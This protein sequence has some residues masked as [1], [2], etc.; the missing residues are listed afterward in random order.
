MAI[1]PK[2]AFEAA[3][4][5]WPEVRRI[6][7]NGEDGWLVVGANRGNIDWGDTDQ[8]P[9]P[10][11]EWVDAVFPMTLGSKGGLVI[12]E[13]IGLEELFAVDGGMVLGLTNVQ[14]GSIAKFKR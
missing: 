11:P 10:E 4:V 2:Q 12:T 13:R 3:K 6:E 7:R 9:L 5:L 14:H 8:Y 1:T